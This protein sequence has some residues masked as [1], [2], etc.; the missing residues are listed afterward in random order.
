MAGPFYGNLGWRTVM[1]AIIDTF[2]LG[3]DAVEEIYRNSSGPRWFFRLNGAAFA[4]HSDLLHGM[5]LFN[6]TLGVTLSI[7]HRVKE[8]FNGLQTERYAQLIA[9]DEFVDPNAEVHRVSRQTN[10]WCFKYEPVKVLRFHITS[11]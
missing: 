5:S 1:D 3:S 6:K 9:A 11:T 8:I 7:V 10:K 4:K 2:R